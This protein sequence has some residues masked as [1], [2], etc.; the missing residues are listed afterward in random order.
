M[1]Q[2]HFLKCSYNIELKVKTKKKNMLFDFLDCPYSRDQ[3]TKTIFPL[4]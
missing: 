4:F 3:N 1:K 2:S